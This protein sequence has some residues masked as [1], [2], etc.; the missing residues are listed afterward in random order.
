MTEQ[1]ND[2]VA[3]NDVEANIE[4]ANQES[5]VTGSMMT[6]V[7]DNLER[8]GRTHSSGGDVTEHPSYDG[9][10]QLGPESDFTRDFYAFDSDRTGPNQGQTDT[11]LTV[12][13]GMRTHG[14]T[15][16]RLVKGTR[17]PIGSHDNPSYVVNVPADMVTTEQVA[18]GL[19]AVQLVQARDMRQSLVLTN[20]DPAN[21][22]FVG[23][24]S[25]VQ[26]VT[27]FPIKAGASFT[28]AAGCELWAVAAAGTPIVAVIEFNNYVR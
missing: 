2:D 19:S 26:V 3:L 7:L 1:I 18:V 28:M 8:I 9:S 27:G 23:A 12:P 25:A 14:A 21:T 17:L 22:V 5:G 11:S 16:D 4:N 24:N 6:T 15:P 13:P 20:T 10:Q